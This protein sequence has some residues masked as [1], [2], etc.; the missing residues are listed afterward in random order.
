MKKYLFAILSVS[1]AGS[2]SAG[3]MES[4]AAGFGVQPA[5]VPPP[6]ASAPQ[7]LQQKL[8]ENEPAFCFER[9]AG[10]MAEDAY[11]PKSFCVSKLSLERRAE[12]KL[13]LY[14]AS[15]HKE[16]SGNSAKY[17]FENGALKYVSAQAYEFFNEQTWGVIEVLA[18]VYP[19]GNLIPG[20]EVKIA[21]KAGLNP[22]S[23]DWIWEPV[24]Y[25]KPKPPQPPAITG[26]CFARNAGEWA[27]EAGMPAKFCVKDAALVR[28]SAGG[29]KL[30][31]QG[32]LAGSY[33][34]TYVERAGKSYVRAVVFDKETGYMS[35]YAGN[36]VLLLPTL[37]N[38]DLDPKGQAQVEA[39]AGY[40]WDIYHS[41]MQYENV[42]YAVTGN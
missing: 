36:V 24:A 8:G 26:S 29:L 30:S 39:Q 20:G 3:T 15:T 27:D 12:G 21:A 38:G 35:V 6:A 34:A 19:N 18:P 9:A 42:S 7:S 11:L 31:L 22:P 17:V 14:L 4:L 32:A 33:A 40:N 28:E 23:G 5:A 13:Y 25:A 1:L 16:M 2:V 41:Q 37:A 10:S